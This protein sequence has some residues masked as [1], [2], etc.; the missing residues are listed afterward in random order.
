[1]AQDVLGGAAKQQVLQAAAPMG[2]HDDEVA[3]V[4]LRQPADHL[5]CGAPRVT[6]VGI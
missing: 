4:L 1:M 2:S 5:T 6:G 3:V